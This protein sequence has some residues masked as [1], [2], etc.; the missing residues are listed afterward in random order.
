MNFDELKKLVRRVGSVV[1]F[2]G[3]KPELV[4]MPY[5]K[6]GIDLDGQK[7]EDEYEQ[8]EVERLNSEILA[9]REE[10]AQREREMEGYDDQGL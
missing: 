7:V 10:L 4:I 8:Q 3:N 2:D 9:L 5:E 1:I 6:A